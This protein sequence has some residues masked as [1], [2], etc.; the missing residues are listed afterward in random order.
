[1]IRA[2]LEKY[3]QVNTC[4]GMGF[5]LVAG[6]TRHLYDIVKRKRRRNQKKRGE[7]EQSQMHCKQ[8]VVR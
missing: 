6:T 7:A 4:V 1:M 8:G 3:E 5:V 2:V